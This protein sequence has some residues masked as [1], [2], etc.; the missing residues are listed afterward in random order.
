[1]DLMN[2]NVLVATQGSYFQAVNVFPHAPQ[3]QQPKKDNVDQII[4]AQTVKLAL[5][6]IF[7]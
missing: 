6:I 2:I 7:A 3:G 4:V 5:L 1:M